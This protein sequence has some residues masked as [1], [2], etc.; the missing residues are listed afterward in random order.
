[1]RHGVCAFASPEAVEIGGTAFFIPPS[2]AS[3]LFLSNASL[4]YTSGGFDALLHR[5]EST[6]KLTLSIAEVS[7]YVH[8]FKTCKW[9]VTL[10]WLH[11]YL[12]RFFQSVRVRLQ[13]PS[14]LDFLVSARTKDGSL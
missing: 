9:C 3:Q 4:F 8:V 6:Q 14:P 7:A 12:E 13:N 5:L 2:G 11:K 10:L 1:M